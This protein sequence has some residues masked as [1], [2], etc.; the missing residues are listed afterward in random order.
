M[1]IRMK[2]TAAAI[3]LLGLAGC[4]TLESRIEG[5]REVFDAFPAQVQ[6]KIT[7]GEIERGFTKP[8]VTIALGDPDDVYRKEDAQ[9]ASEIW[10]YKG[11]RQ[12]Y[13]TTYSMGVPIWAGRHCRQGFYPNAYVPNE[14]SWR[15]DYTRATVTF[16]G[17]RVVE[18]NLKAK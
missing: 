2:A 1:M 15:E 13:V 5:N 14:V 11:Y 18:F 8:M 9:G 16:R 10:I 17:G 3:G 4:S 6:R 7:A 12:Q